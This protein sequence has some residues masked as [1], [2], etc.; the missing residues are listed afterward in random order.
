MMKNIVGLEIEIEKIEA[1][2]KFNQNVAEVDAKGV[3][4]NYEKEV[5]GEKGTYMSTKTKALYPKE[6]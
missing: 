6:I 1:K 5:G 3:V 4:E 2:F